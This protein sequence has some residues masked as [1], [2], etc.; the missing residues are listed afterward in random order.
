DVDTQVK[1]AGK[2]TAVMPNSSKPKA[3][4]EET[5]SLVTAVEAAARSFLETEMEAILVHE[6]EQANGVY[7]HTKATK[8]E[9]EF[10]AAW[11]S[12]N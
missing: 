10:F 4:A 7:L 1:A 11:W 2:V 9:G 5:G 6:S 12:G 8:A 3:T